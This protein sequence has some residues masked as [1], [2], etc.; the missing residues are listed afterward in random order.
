MPGDIDPISGKPVSEVS[1][2][3]WV[4]REDVSKVADDPRYV[5]VQQYKIREV[6]YKDSGRLIY[7]QR[8]DVGGSFTRLTGEARREAVERYEYETAKKSVETYKKYEE[9]DDPTLKR[10]YA[11]ETQLQQH[12][13]SDYLVPIK[14]EPEYKEV[15]LR[16]GEAFIGGKVVPA[17]YPGTPTEVAYL[18]LGKEYFAAPSQEVFT[19]QYRSAYERLSP[20]QKAEFNVKYMDWSDVP[21]EKIKYYL[22]GKQYLESLPPEEKKRLISRYITEHPR[23]FELTPSKGGE[24][25]FQSVLKHSPILGVPAAIGSFIFGGEKT[26]KKAFEFGTKEWKIE[27]AWKIITTDPYTLKQKEYESFDPFSKAIYSTSYAT[28]S[29]I[30]WPVTLTQTGVKYITGKGAVTDPFGR[31]KTGETLILPD[32]SKELGERKLGGPSGIISVGISE[33]VSKLTGEPTK[34]WETA[35][36]YPVETGFAT[37]G[38]L[39]GLWAGGRAV[40]IGKASVSA[41]LKKIGVPGIPLKYRP[42]QLIRKGYWKGRVRLGLAEELPPETMFKPGTLPSGLSYVP[43]RTSAERIANLRRAFKETK[44]ITTTGEE[45][46]AG[47]HTTAQSWFKPIVIL[48][49]GRESPG[50]SFAPIGKGTPRFLRITGEPSIYEIR[51]ISLFPKIRLPTAPV[52]LN[53]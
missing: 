10:V 6:R 9:T 27:K 23:E 29:A 20:V 37:V 39:V 12:I 51:G 36:K 3:S 1:Y 45:S 7:T 46:F 24:F 42:V 49:K 22:G 28:L 47:V 31:I 52:F 50:V 13:G 33:G 32:V 44:V 4:M 43:G 48:R 8:E 15:T 19:R 41:G 16:P 17:T 18:G 34:E 26:V 53:S 2:G 30:S 35:Q 21:V 14:K 5:R 40:G 38:E 11:R 25:V